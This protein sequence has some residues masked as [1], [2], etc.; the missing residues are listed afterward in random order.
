MY[1]QTVLLDNKSSIIIISSIKQ[2]KPVF[3]I[4]PINSL[5]DD[6]DALTSNNPAERQYH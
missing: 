6:D 4:V 1:P 5:D 2:T 3:I